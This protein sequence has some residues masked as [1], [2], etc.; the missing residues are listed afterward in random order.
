VVGLVIALALV[1]GSIGTGVG[2]IL[3]GS[4][5][6]AVT[7]VVDSVLPA[8]GR[9]AGPGFEEVTLTLSNVS[10][11]PVTPVCSVSVRR[12]GVTLGSVTARGT[13]PLGSGDR[14]SAVVAV[15]VDRRPFAGTAADAQASCAG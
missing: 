9:R 4:S 14:V 2:I 7:S 12:D 3:G 13:R 6:P 1:L 11:G 10:S 5:G 8:P 15:P